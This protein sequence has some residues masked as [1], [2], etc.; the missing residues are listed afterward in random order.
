MSETT[1]PVFPE[2][3]F[4]EEIIAERTE[5]DPEFPTLVQAAT[6]KRKEV[7]A[8]AFVLAWMRNDNLSDVGKAVGLSVQ[9]VRARAEKYR[10]DGVDLPVKVR[11]KKKEKVNVK[12]LNDLIKAEA[13]AATGDV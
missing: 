3:D 10:Q 2:P 5:V 8:A 6:V 11:G 9:S 12:E 4:L 13:E 7:S 1:G